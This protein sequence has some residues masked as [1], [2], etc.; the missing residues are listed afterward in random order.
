MNLPN[1]P[2][3]N[4]YKFMALTGILIIVL[5]STLFI[6]KGNRTQE[7]NQELKKLGSLIDSE[8]SNKELVILRLKNDE[9]FKKNY[10]A[11]NSISVYEAETT[12]LLEELKL[13]L[14]DKPTYR[15]IALV[16]GFLGIT[17]SLFGFKLWYEKV[18]KYQDIILENEAT[19]RANKNNN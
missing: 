17:L 18:Q 2:T 16:F 3:D 15:L 1:I 10:K 11:D 4:L 12:K 14:K 6:V 19:T 9:T 7:I 5:S 8:L 13:I